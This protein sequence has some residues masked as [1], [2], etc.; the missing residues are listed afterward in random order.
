MLSER[1]LYG[2]YSQSIS[3]TPTDGIARRLFLYE[4][5]QT[6]RKDDDAFLVKRIS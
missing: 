5:G 1:T 6:V 2:R 4:S 3:T